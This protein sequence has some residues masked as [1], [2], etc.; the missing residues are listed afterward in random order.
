M[1]GRWEHFPHEADIDIR[2]FGATLAEAF[3]HAALAMSAA[4]CELG[5][6]KVPQCFAIIWQAHDREV[7]F[8]E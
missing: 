1:A 8:V 2:R 6:I 3:E 4:I 7:L 5:A